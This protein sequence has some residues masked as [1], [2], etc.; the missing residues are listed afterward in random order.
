MT[1]Q[2]RSLQWFGGYDNQCAWLKCGTKP[3]W[4][5]SIV[6]CWDTPSIE[7]AIRVL[8]AAAT[9]LDIPGYAPFSI[10]A[11]PN[12]SIAAI[13]GIGML[14]RHPGGKV[15]FRAGNMDFDDP[16]SLLILRR[17]LANAR[18]PVTIHIGQLTLPLSTDSVIL[19]ALSVLTTKQRYF[20]D[21]VRSNTIY[22][23]DET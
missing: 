23:P 7:L 21:A 16:Y 8:D 20:P 19:D 22:V 14:E 15:V 11:G 6:R 2:P 17:W 3:D 13:D 1:T 9:R 5:L 4:I 12:E 18:P 10:E